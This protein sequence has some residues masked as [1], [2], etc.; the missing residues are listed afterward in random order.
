LTVVSLLAAIGT[1]WLGMFVAHRYA[2]PMLGGA[3]IGAGIATMHYI[4][5]AALR[6]AAHKHLD[7]DYVLAS[8]A[9]GMTFA[10]AGIRVT[11]WGPILR[12][13]LMAVV[14]LVLANCGLHFTALAA[15]VSFICQPALS[16]RGCGRKPARSPSG[17]SSPRVS[18]ARLA[19]DC[20]NAR[21]VARAD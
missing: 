2:T 18:M 17:P 21:T 20:P 4:G 12:G 19:S 9:I 1:A 14:L 13:R 16:R 15:L 8:V 7:A 5:M 3:M 11:S 6:A 10:A